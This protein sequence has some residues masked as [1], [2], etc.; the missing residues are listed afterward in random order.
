[1]NVQELFKS[2]NED[3]FLDLYLRNDRESIDMLFNTK[4]T[5]E[6]K[7]KKLQYYRQIVLDA[8]RECKNMQIK[9]SSDDIVFVVPNFD[10]DTSAD[11]F[12][13]KKEEFLNYENIERPEHY[14]YDLSPQ[15]EV[16]G[17]NINEA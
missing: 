9:E 3:E 12:V 1:M 17:N 15:D 16:L 2:I 4:Y 14:G 6:E 7:F 8:F 10:G 11:S 13:C 5:P